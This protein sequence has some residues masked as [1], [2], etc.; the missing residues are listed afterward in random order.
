MPRKKRVSSVR[1]EGGKI[2]DIKDFIAEEVAECDK[3]IKDWLSK[4]GIIREQDIPYIHRPDLVKIRL[5]VLHYL[6]YI[7]FDD[8]TKTYIKNDST[9]NIPIGKLPINSDKLDLLIFAPFRKLIINIVYNYRPKNHTDIQEILR[10]VYGINVHLSS[11]TNAMAYLCKLGFVKALGYGLGYVADYNVIVFDD[12]I[13]AYKE[14]LR[15]KQAKLKKYIEGR[16]PWRRK[17]K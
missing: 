15:N 17:K 16:E 14:W 8:A 7:D 2:I 6:G 12:E 11:V 1:G 9:E 13:E 4:F 3:K 10:E 5:K